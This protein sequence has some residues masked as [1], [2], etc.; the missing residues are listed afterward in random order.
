[1]RTA[2]AVATRVKA[3]LPLFIFSIVNNW[4]SLPQN[5]NLKL[6]LSHCPFTA[7]GALPGNF[8]KFAPLNI[9]QRYPLA[10]R[11]MWLLQGV[12]LFWQ[13]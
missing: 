6:V 5:V 2:L 1:M 8:H 10:P 3:P 12:H 9:Y 13:V 4:F 11:V 7:P